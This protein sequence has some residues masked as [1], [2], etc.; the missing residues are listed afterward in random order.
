[1]GN[2]ATVLDLFQK[3]NANNSKTTICVFSFTDWYKEFS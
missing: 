2:L 3:K 1:M